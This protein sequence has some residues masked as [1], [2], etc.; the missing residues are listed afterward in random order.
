MYTF[1]YLEDIHRLKNRLPWLRLNLNSS[2]VSYTL[3]LVEV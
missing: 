1:F 2:E 3:T